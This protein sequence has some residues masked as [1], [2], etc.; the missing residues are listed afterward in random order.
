MMNLRAG[1]RRDA[2]R[3]AVSLAVAASGN[4][5]RTPA[6]RFGLKRE[7]ATVSSW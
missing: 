5:G 4:I 7:T 6:Y 1:D 2:R 3:A